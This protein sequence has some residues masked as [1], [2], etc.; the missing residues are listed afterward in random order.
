[1]FVAVGLC[2]YYKIGSRKKD[3][4]T[5]V[6]GEDW[7][8]VI[9]CDFYVAYI[10][11]ANGRP[12]VLLQHCLAHLKRDFQ[13]CKENLNPEI[14][15]YGEK[16]LEIHAKLFEAWDAYK[17]DRSLNNRLELRKWGAKLNE[18]AVIGPNRGKPKSI[19]ARFRDH[20]GSYTLFIEHDNVEPTNNAAERAVR[21][22]I[23]VRYVTQG[24]RGGTGMRAMERYW[25]VSGTC[26]MQGKSFFE[27]FKS[28]LVAMLDGTAMPSIFA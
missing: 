7:V 2:V 10:S 9:I 19:A 25:S 21:R 27:F 16:M 18:E 12:C 15:R 17:A 22:I 13:N 8:G 4:L 23:A 14:S 6:L 20:P 24:T 5:I 3:M 11:Y 28:C 1:V 26:A